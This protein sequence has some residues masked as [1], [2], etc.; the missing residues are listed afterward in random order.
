MF[1][2]PWTVIQ[3]LTFPGIVIYQITHKFMCD[4][5]GVTV[6]DVKYFS[7]EDV[8]WYVIYDETDSLWKHFLIAITPFIINSLICILLTFPIA[9]SIFYLEIDIENPVLFILAWVGISAW[10]HAIPYSQDIKNL[11][12]HAKENH[13]KIVNYLFISPL[14]F[15]VILAN[16]LKVVWFD[17]IY[18]FLIWI[19]LPILLLKLL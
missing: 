4:I 15:F 18:A 17:F 8:S 9:I 16:T 11:K 5:L 14:Y 3:I 10:V 7:F 19:S 6:Y 1:F 13:N 2:I 12:I